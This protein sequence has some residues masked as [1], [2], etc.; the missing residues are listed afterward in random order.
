MCRNGV[1]APVPLRPVVGL[2]TMDKKEVFGQNQVICM[3]CGKGFTVIGRHLGAAH[4]MTADEYRAK[5]DIPL[6]TALASRAYVAR[7]KK[8]TAQDKELK[9]ELDQTR[10]AYE[11]LKFKDPKN[12]LSLVKG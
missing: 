2:F 7:R 10:A 4:G 6:G 12:K 1:K 5:F 3:I 9:A 8:E 11:K